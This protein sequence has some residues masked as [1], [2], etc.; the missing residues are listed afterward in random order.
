MTLGPRVRAPSCLALVSG[1]LVILHAQQV[2]CVQPG[3]TWE[4]LRLHKDRSVP[5]FQGTKPMP[6]ISSSSLHMGALAQGRGQEF[7]CF[8]ASSHLL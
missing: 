8:Q 1:P 4:S 2:V 3:M 5:L 7:T 6:T